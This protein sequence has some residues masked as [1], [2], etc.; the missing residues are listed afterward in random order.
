MLFLNSP[1][2]KKEQIPGRSI[3]AIFNGDL[4]SP[5]ILASAGVANPK[6]PYTKSL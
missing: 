2:T 4:A 3:S 5:T 6:P 1:P